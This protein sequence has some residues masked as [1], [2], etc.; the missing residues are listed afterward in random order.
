M[1]SPHS[2]NS[3][4]PGNIAGASNAEFLRKVARRLLREAHSAR[5]SAAMPVIRRV[6]RAGVLPVQRVA[7]LYHARAALQLKH[8]LRM[9]AIELGYPGWDACKH[10]IDRRPASALDRFRLDLG[11]FGDYNQVW[12]ATEAEAQQWQQENGGR[13][14]VYG[15]QAVVMTG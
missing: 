9:V 15:A 11:A 1:H 13:I 14:V 8:M 3:D 4:C 2:P 10:D 7:D 6:H 12:F 5:P